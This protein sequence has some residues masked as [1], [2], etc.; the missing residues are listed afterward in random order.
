MKET[1]RI[2]DNDFIV[3]FEGQSSGPSEKKILKLNQNL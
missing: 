3:S 1:L 2:V